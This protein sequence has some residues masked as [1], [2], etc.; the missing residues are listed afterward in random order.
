MAFVC[1][2]LGGGTGSGA[3]PEV[4]RIAKEEGVFLVVFATL[5]FSFEGRRRMDQALDAL[6]RISKYA[7]AVITFE[8]DRMGELIVPKEGVQQAFA[9][10]DKI[11][12]QSIRATMGIVSH[13]G[14][15]RIGMDDLLSALDSTNS[16]CLFGFGQAKGDNR[17]HEALEQALKC[18]LLDKGKLLQDARNVLVHVGGGE[19]MTLYEIQ[20]VMRE[21]SKHIDDSR[22]QILFGTGTD[23]KLGGSL[24]VT[25]V[26]SL[27]GQIGEGRPSLSGARSQPPREIPEEASARIERIS[28]TGR[29]LDRSWPGRRSMTVVK[30]LTRAV[31]P[32]KPWSH[33][34][35]RNLNWRRKKHSWTILYPKNIPWRRKQIFPNRNRSKHGKSS[36]R[37]CRIIRRRWIRLRANTRNPEGKR[38]NLNRFTRSGVLPPRRCRNCESR[39]G[40][41]KPPW[42]RSAWS[43]SEPLR[44]SPFAPPA[45]EERSQGQTR[46]VLRVGTGAKADPQSPA[47]GPQEWPRRAKISIRDLARRGRAQTEPEEMPPAAME[48]VTREDLIVAETEDAQKITLSRLVPGGSSVNRS[49][50]RPQASAQ[51]AP[52]VAREA[53]AEIDEATAQ[54]QQMLHLEPLAK[55]RFAKSEPTIVHGE[56]VDVPTFLRKRK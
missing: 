2:G 34:P 19:S 43:Q 49:E 41:W 26:S 37:W 47:E 40:W 4:A 20:L 54:Q 1:V 27:E 18:P 17:A 31:F 53:D 50:E 9:A 12:S 24:T 29:D 30:R 5:P 32:W 25:V 14:I 35:L 51:S 8:N 6:E 38:N 52:R 33:H 15:I 45:S 3:A 11:I 21:L 56:D 16:R 36:H 22:T 10:A 48:S 28:T 39:R 13:P 46:P 44:K 7:N 42:F 55:G 23:K